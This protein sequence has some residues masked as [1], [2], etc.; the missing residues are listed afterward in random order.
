M[1]DVGRAAL[2]IIADME[3]CGEMQL[4]LLRGRMREI[5]WSGDRTG[6]R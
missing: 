6:D 4:K 1:A 5:F 3:L 2:E